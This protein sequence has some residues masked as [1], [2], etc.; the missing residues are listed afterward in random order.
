M[1][2]TFELTDSQEVVFQGFRK[3]KEKEK[4]KV[5]KRD[6]SSGGDFTICFTFT[7]IGIVVEAVCNFDGSKLDLT[8]EENW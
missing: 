3:K 1:A 2:L 7:G 8:E 6:A 5:K 4:R